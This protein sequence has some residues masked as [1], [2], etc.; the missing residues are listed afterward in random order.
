MVGII[1]K[2]IEEIEFYFRNM[3]LHGYANNLKKIR[4]KSDVATQYSK[5]W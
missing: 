4:G 1:A 5:H 2:L 3:I